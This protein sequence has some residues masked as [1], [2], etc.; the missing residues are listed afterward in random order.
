MTA[1]GINSGLLR[2]YMGHTADATTAHYSQLATRYAAVVEGWPRGQ[3]QLMQ[4]MHTGWAC[5]WPRKDG[6][7]L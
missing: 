5:A 1:T 7:N 6:A 4:G 2:A 3:F